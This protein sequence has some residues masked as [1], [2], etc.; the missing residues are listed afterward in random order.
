MLSPFTNV[1]THNCSVIIVLYLFCVPYLRSLKKNHD[2]SKAFHTVGHDILFKKLSMYGVR[3]NPFSWF[4]SYLDNRK[5]F[6]SFNG[7]K[8]DIKAV[9]YGVPQGSILGPLFFLLCINDL[10]DICSQSFPILFAEDFN[11]FNH[12]K[13]FSS[14]QM[15][16]SKELAEMS[17]WLKVN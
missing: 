16:L 4:Q 17:K 6:A 12:G 10:A 15:S 7:A 8:S 9:K 2:F 13:D 3:G 5:Q 11:L 1:M 14:L